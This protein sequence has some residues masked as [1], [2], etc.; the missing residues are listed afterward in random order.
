[1]RMIK[2]STLNLGICLSLSLFSSIAMS[3]SYLIKNATLHTATAKGM[4]KN[5]DILIENGKIKDVGQDLS[6]SKEATVI[7]GKGKHVTPGLINASTTMGLVE[8]SAVSS[9]VDS[10]TTNHNMGAAFNIAAAINFR[11]TLVP[12]NRIN[13]LTRAIVLPRSSES[14]FA[15]Q[16]AAI[17]LQSSMQGM[18]NENIAQVAFYGD[19][20]AGIAGGSRAAAMRILEQALI[21]ARYLRSH[22]ARYL[23][24]FRWE[25]SLPVTDLK[26]LY[27]VLE[28]KTPLIITANRSDDILRLISLAKKHRF[29]LVISGGGEAWM[30]AEELADAGVPVIMDPMRNLP[31]FESLSVRLDGAAKLYQAGVTLLFT[32]GGTHNGYLVRQSAGNAVAY[33]LPAEAAIEAMTINTA[34]VFSIK[35]YGQLEVGMEA[36]LVIWDGEPLELTSTPDMV[37]IQGKSQPLVSRATR[38]RDRYWELDRTNR[39]IISR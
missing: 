19:Q 15:G 39:S 35:D 20:G 33:G 6:A 7:D 27:P 16:G 9:T 10:A 30:V 34:E 18:L 24:G 23:P 4:L 31:Q 32:G 17:A 21:D 3:E 5:A 13:G 11:S 8:I 29:N 1:M 22:E 37:L 26:A 38:L 14:I 28:R 12:H 2:S 36:D 25:F